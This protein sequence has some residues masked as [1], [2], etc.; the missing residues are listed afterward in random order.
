[1]TPLSVCLWGGGLVPFLHSSFNVYI[2]QT[3][4]NTVGT[5]RR[6]QFEDGTPRGIIRSPALVPSHIRGG[7]RGSGRVQCVWCMS[8]VVRGT[9]QN[10]GGRSR[11][12][13]HTYIR[14]F[15]T[16]SVCDRAPNMLSLLSSG[17]CR[18]GTKRSERLFEAFSSLRLCQIGFVCIF[19]H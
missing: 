14:R 13:L 7:A 18:G 6:K 19:R 8:Y 4:R 11:G 16:L 9:T 5:K 3:L 1:M 10:Y 2:Q 12:L 17:Q 15:K